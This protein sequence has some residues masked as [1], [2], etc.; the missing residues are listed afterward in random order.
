MELTV[1]QK[2]I[3][4][5]RGQRVMLDRDLAELY[6]VTTGNLNLAV[7]RNIKK[8]PKDFMFQLTKQEFKNL[9]LQNA[10]SSWGGTR[11][12][13]YAFTE[14]G[15]AMLSSVLKSQKAVDVNISIIRAFILLRQMA[16][17]H[18][19]LFKKIEELQKKYDKNFEEVYEALNSLLSPPEKPRKRVGYK[20]FD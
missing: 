18:K 2:K 15:V 13:P 7:K 8:F 10:I 6:Q 5:I 9:I 3:F 1:I 12:M 20:H 11:K 16:V 4:E 19:E 17:S 14:H